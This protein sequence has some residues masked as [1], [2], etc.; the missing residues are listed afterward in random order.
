MRFNSSLLT[1]YAALSAMR[2]MHLPLN[3]C[4]YK[5]RKCFTYVIVISRNIA[6]DAWHHIFLGLLRKISQI[7]CETFDAL[8][9]YVVIQTVLSLYVSGIVLGGAD[10]MELEY[11]LMICL[12]M[13]CV[14]LVVDLCKDTFFVAHL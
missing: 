14:S 5:S 10:D 2:L 8:A 13:L 9:M 4:W 3:H 7:K 12:C 1:A 11:E 6:A